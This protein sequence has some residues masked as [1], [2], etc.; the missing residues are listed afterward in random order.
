MGDEFDDLDIEMDEQPRRARRLVLGETSIAAGEPTTYDASGEHVEEGD[1]FDANEPLPPVPAHPD[2]KAPPSGPTDQQREW[3][4]ER[5][6]E[7]ELGESSLPADAAL[8]AARALPGGAAI[9][10]ADAAQRRMGA[11][12]LAAGEEWLANVGEGARGAFGDTPVLEHLVGL[13]PED[14]GSRAPD[15][16]IAGR[17]RRAE[18]PIAGF[19]DAATLGWDDELAG[20]ASTA[21]GGDYEATRDRVRSMSDDAQAQ[22][23]GSFAI[24]QAA[25]TLPWL[26]APNPAGAGGR[27]ALGALMGGADAAGHSQET[28]MALA[29]DTALGAG[30]GAG[31]GAL[32]EGALAVA[33]GPGEGAVRQRALSEMSDAADDALLAA[34]GHAGHNRGAVE[35]FDFGDDRRAIRESR[36]RAAQ[37]LRDTEAIPAAA[38][39]RTTRRSIED[40]LAGATGTMDD[41]RTA[42]GSSG[43]TGGEIAERLRAE[44]SGMRS[45][46]SAQIRDVLDDFAERYGGIEEVVPGTTGTRQ[47][48]V[49]PRDR[50][51]SEPIDYKALIEQLGH[52]RDSGSW[53]TR[54][55]RDVPL[56]EQGRR[57]VDRALRAAY[58]D[59][60]EQQ[61]SRAAAEGGAFRGVDLTPQ[62]RE[63]LQR[64][65][66]DPVSRY[67]DARRQY[68]VLD[69]ALE[70]AQRGEAAL[71]GNR[72]VGM[73]EMQWGGAG[74]TAGATIGSALGPIGAGGGA[75]LGG[76]LGAGAAR[77]WRGIE[78]RVRARG[79]Q[80]VYELAQRMPELSERTIGGARRAL[81]GLRVGVGQ[82]ADEVVLDDPEPTPPEMP[83]ANAAPEQA[84]ADPLDAFGDLDIEFEETP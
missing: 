10:G 6:T 27:I 32:G 13:I 48:P 9:H 67:R 35:A 53:R 55:G 23:P 18:A 70:N 78:P 40:A 19:S 3:W 71:A 65:G 11:R 25:G 17:D 5:E 76:A 15:R 7:R 74:A 80:A 64:L 72:A 59:A 41:V 14:T 57:R 30:L 47:V 31:L 33:R 83:S 69:T 51:P 49:D 73:S 81:G 8:A 37:V 77:T 58:D 20:A 84:E 34:T 46:T 68:A 29:G 21:A 60:I 12:G 28:G 39:I 56:G 24:G 44:A 75:A 4:E 2:E 52:L 54:A 62:Q 82:G 61:A 45:P 26:A 79:A 50:H 42:M 66:E 43:P 38:G 22:A 1:E 16:S 63:A 36:G